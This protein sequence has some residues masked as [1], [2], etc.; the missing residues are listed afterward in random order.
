MSTTTSEATMAILD[1]E[2]RQR[3]EQLERAIDRGGLPTAVEAQTVWDEMKQALDPLERIVMRVEGMA[4]ANDGEVKV[5]FEQ[6]GILATLLEDVELNADELAQNV[7]RIRKAMFG[8]S[9][10]IDRPDPDVVAQEG[11]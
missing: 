6:F 3:L 7:R 4:G 10:L 1:Q 5:T 8:L 11:N 2:E 9:S